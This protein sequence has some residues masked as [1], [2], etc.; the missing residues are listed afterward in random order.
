M[1][2][3]WVGAVDHVLVGQ[4]PAIGVVDEAGADA[5]AGVRLRLDLDDCRHGAVD[6]VDHR[7]RLVDVHLRDVRAERRLG[8]RRAVLVG[9]QGRVTAAA[10]SEP[11]TMPATTASAT[12]PPPAARRRSAG[13]GGA[14]ATGGCVDHG[15]TDWG[16]TLYGEGA[17]CVGGGPNRRTS[18]C[19]VASSP[20]CGVGGFSSVMSLGSLVAT[21]AEGNHRD[22]A[23]LRQAA[24][25]REVS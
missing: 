19:S 22:P 12:T 24:G 25:V 3:S 10:D 14:A 13:R 15:G 2:V 18:T 8:G 20:V 9:Q 21:R 7:R 23:R 4:D 11:D 5:A 17:A 1:T 16:G 6:G